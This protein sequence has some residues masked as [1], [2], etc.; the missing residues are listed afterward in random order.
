[1]VSKCIY[2]ILLVFSFTGQVYASHIVGGYIRYEH[3]GNGL[4][5]IQLFVYRDCN[6]MLNT[7]PLDPRI[8]F[9]IFYETSGEFLLEES[10]TTNLRNLERQEL[11]ED[12]CLELP[13]GLCIELGR[14]EITY[15]VEDWPR[16]TPVMF[17]Y[18]RCCRNA[19]ISNIHDP[20][21]TGV[22][23]FV[24]LTPE[25]MTLG[26]S[27]PVFHNIPP[28]VTCVNSL[29]T[30]EPDVTD[31]NE[32]DLRYSICAPRIG[33]GADISPSGFNSCNG[34]IPKPV[35][36]PPYNDV[37][38][39]SPYTYNSPFPGSS[40]MTIDNETGFFSVIPDL[41]GQ[42]VSS[43]CIEEWVNGVKIGEIRMEFQVNVTQCTPVLE[44]D[45]EHTRKVEPDEYII[46]WCGGLD[47]VIKNL[48]EIKPFVRDFTWEIDI[49][50][51]IRV[52]NEYD[53]RIRFPEY[54][55]FYGKLFYNKGL[56]CTDSIK[57][58]IHVLGDVKADFNYSFD[59][60]VLEA[61]QFDNL[62]TTNGQGITSYL[63]LS[64]ND[65]ISTNRDISHL[66]DSS[67]V[68]EMSLVVEDLN[69]CKDTITKQ[70]LYYPI[71]AEI[72]IDSLNLIGCNPFEVNF[73][74]LNPYISSDHYIEWD[75]GDG[76]TSNERNPVHIYSSTGTYSVSLFIRNI[77]GCEA[78]IYLDNNIV[79]NPPP[80]ASFGYSPTE[81]SRLNPTVTFNNTSDD[82]YMSFWIFGNEGNSE[83]THPVHT[84]RDTGLIDVT[85]II[86]NIYGCKDTVTTKIDIIPDITY[87]MPNAFTPYG[88]G[89]T[90]F[91]GNG[92]LDGIK[93]F[94]LSIFNRYGQELFYTRNHSAGWNGRINNTG[95]MQTS[96]NY[97]YLVEIIGPR[98]IPLKLR[99]N[100]LLIN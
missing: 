27:S 82:T 52:F 39:I 65:T 95:E 51:T 60:C 5:T 30:F 70:I 66:Y 87:F 43:M 64:D 3:L 62:S 63:W 92:F 88:S 98:G 38:F 77:Y 45:V 12:P 73:D 8:D 97:V 16:Q 58:T 42:Y 7:V 96:G 18:Q 23:F 55:T 79:V 91:I 44:L 19:T 56:E 33:G 69:G 86:T 41:Q 54:D 17:A 72:L 24:E 85:L 1:M 34:G 81:I 15:R 2:T 53:L 78:G 57:L 75:F 50:D 67:G 37:I 100:F 11:S 71:P 49:E 20:G 14:Y 93:D 47:G 83:L 35:C 61:V 9:G 10:I 89:N 99:G 31:Q 48:T 25:A 40:N 22:T 26:N 28:F 21:N 94:N 74:V 76:N 84:F 68:Y 32:D 90:I 80:N 4:Y 6:P 36:P 46:E 29:L 59:T 13:P